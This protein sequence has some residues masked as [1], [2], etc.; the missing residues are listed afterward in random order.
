[1]H[2]S[3]KQEL[4]EI[5]REK[6]IS[7]SAERFQRL[8]NQLMEQVKALEMLRRWTVHLFLPIAGNKEP[9]TYAM[10]AWL[11]Q[12][13]PDIRLVLPKTARGSREMKHLVW[14]VGT[15]LVPNRWGIPEP[16]AGTIVRPHEIDV[17]FLPLLAFDER[18]NRIGYGK[19]FYDRFLANC[20]PTTQKIGLSLFEAVETIS[21]V[22]AHDVAM[23]ICVTPTR[24]WHFNTAP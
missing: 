8:N 2:P 22:S 23:D 13:Y 18:G 1:M 16:E 5:Y 10:A 4:R 6:R 11:R 17:V 20:R 24:L 21:D 3:T 9:D 15:V 12:Q 19:G 14:D 7:L